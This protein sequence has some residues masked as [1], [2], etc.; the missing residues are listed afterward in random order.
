LFNLG[1][2]NILA[3]YVDAI[4]FADGLGR[5]P[6]CFPLNPALIIVDLGLKKIKIKLLLLLLY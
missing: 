2:A 1:E 3:R 6:C 4:S 5:S